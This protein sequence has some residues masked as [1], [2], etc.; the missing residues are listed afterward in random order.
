MTFQKI[1]NFTFGQFLLLTMLMITVGCAIKPVSNNH[2]F[3]YEARRD[4]P[5]IE[6]LAYYYGS[7]RKDAFALKQIDG[8]FPQSFGSWT[9]GP[10]A[11]EL[12]VKW[13]IKNTGE[14]L[15]D[16][17]VLKGRLPDSI[18]N[19]RVH[20]VVRGRQLWVYLMMPVTQTYRDGT[21][22]SLPNL[23]DFKKSDAE[24]NRFVLY[25]IQPKTETK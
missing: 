4:S 18:E 1:R 16:L 2:A 13:R 15:E 21:R 14:V 8:K 10:S 12:Y 11:D 6:I 5:E 19:H 9:P 25:P 17:V 3:G 20:V 24:D 23:P 7:I 22:I